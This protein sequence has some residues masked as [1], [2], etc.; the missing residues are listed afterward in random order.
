[1][2]VF[3]GLLYNKLRIS[4][5]KFFNFYHKNCANIIAY[6]YMVAYQEISYLYGVKQA[7]V[8]NE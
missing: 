8:S 3:K 1:M 7:I 4:G 2:E 6:R 5:S